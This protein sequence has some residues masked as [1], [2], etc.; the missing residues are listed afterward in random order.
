VLTPRQVEQIISQFERLGVPSH[1]GGRLWTFGSSGISG[2]EM[3]RRLRRLPDGAG[4]AAV[5]AALCA[6]QRDDQSG[7]TVAAT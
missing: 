3:L 4:I 1:D 2:A 7:N 5:N 6:N